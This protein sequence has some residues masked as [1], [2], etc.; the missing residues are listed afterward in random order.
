MNN[1]YQTG[2]KQ[3]PRQ[4]GTLQPNPPCSERNNLFQRCSRA[5]TTIAPLKHASVYCSLGADCPFGLVAHVHTAHGIL[6]RSKSYND[7]ISI[8]NSSSE[9]SYTS[10]ESSNETMS[11]VNLPINVPICNNATHDFQFT[12]H[13]SGL[14]E[15]NAFTQGTTNVHYSLPHGPSAVAETP[16]IASPCDTLVYDSVLHHL[17][18]LKMN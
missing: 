6:T 15:A 18:Q 7:L 16:F 14:M 12:S 11:K 4:P 1:F 8:S 10:S 2:D 3:C 5:S 13:S 9:E 17:N